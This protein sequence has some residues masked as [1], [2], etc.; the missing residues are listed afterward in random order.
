MTTILKNRIATFSQ[1]LDHDYRWRSKS[2][3]SESMRRDP[4]PAWTDSRMSF[5]ICSLVI[6]RR[7]YR[8]ESTRSVSDLCLKYHLSENV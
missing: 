8:S 5:A 2:E 4:L 1:N 7:W 6:A 3:R